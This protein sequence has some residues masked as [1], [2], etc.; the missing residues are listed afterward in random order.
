MNDIYWSLG[1]I[2]S[3]FALPLFLFR[4]PVTGIDNSFSSDVSVPN[5]RILNSS[6]STSL[7]NRSSKRLANGNKT[8]LK[9]VTTAK[10]VL[11]DFDSSFLLGDD[12]SPKPASKRVHVHFDIDDNSENKLT[13]NQ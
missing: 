12:S 9:Q 3:H 8:N 13:D 4:S 6:P 5:F 10:S 7:E 1:H 2:Y 11:I